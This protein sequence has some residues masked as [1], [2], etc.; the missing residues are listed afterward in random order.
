MIKTRDDQNCVTQKITANRNSRRRLPPFIQTTETLTCLACAFLLCGLSQQGSIAY[1]KSDEYSGGQEDVKVGMLVGSAV[2]TNQAIVCLDESC[3]STGLSNLC[4][5]AD[6]Q[7]SADFSMTILLLILFAV[8]TFWQD[9]KSQSLD[10]SVQTAQD[11]SVMVDDPRPEDGDV[12]EWKDF[13][14]QF[15]HVTFI[16]IAKNNGPVLKALAARRAVMREIIM[17]LGNGSASTVEDDDGILD[18]KWDGVDFKTK[19]EQVVA[20]E[21]KGEYPDKIAKRRSQIEKIGAFGMKPMAKLQ[22]A[23]AKANEDV[24]K[25]LNDAA[26]DSG[27]PVPSKIFITFETEYAQRKCLEALTRG[28]IPAAMDSGKDKMA[29]EHV[30]KSENVLAVKEAPEPSEVFWEDVDVTFKIRMK[31]QTITFFIVFML[32]LASTLVCKGLAASMGAGGAALWITITNI[33]MPMVLR[34]ICT[35][36]EDH[37]SANDQN[38]SLFLKLTF[39]RWMN[40]AIVLYWITD[41]DAFLTEK[42]L[43]N[44]QAVILAD[45]VTSPLIRTLNP[46]DLINQFIICRY[47]PTQEKMNSYFLGTPWYPAERYADMTKTLFLSL[48]FSSLFPFGLYLTALGYTFIYVVDKYSLLRSWKTDKPVDDDMTKISRMHMIFAVYCHCVMSM[49]FFSEF[50]FDGVC[51]NNGIGDDDGA[52][53]AAENLDDGHFSKLPTTLDWNV[54]SEAQELYGVTTDQIYHPCDQS[55]GSRLIA[56]MF[57]G[58]KAIERESTTGQQERTVRMYGVFVVILTCILFVLFFGKGVIMG[59]FNLWYGTYKGDGTKANADQFT[60][61]GDIMAYIPKIEHPSLAFP[62]IATDVTTFESKYLSFTLQSEPE[63]YVQSLFNKNE[64]PAFSK[65]E[66]K[67]LFSEVHYFPPPAGLTEEPPPKK[68][69]KKKGEYEAV[70][71]QA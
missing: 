70:D 38:Y 62:L 36:F 48:F 17:K 18:T 68:V 42:A 15:G 16:T 6:K 60:T 63:Y 25:A 44:V 37:V 45:A 65:T 29:P 23:L 10:M 3:S 30:F 40:T 28:L 32:V 27:R 1:Y 14:G 9:K 12:Q 20:F 21:E 47:A 49:V 33:I 26:D 71:S 61:C 67:D 7:A 4:M 59:C 54:Y 5:M 57:I 41:F 55:V 39:F 53:A 31:Q 13:F 24:Q 56:I 64:L 35:E 19:M 69:K 22:D 58:D 51:P 43:K 66:M 2:C 46:A 52:A 11:Y 8:I 34:K 50:P